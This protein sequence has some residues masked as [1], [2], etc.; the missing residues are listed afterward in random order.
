[1][2]GDGRLD[3]Q[4]SIPAVKGDEAASRYQFLPTGWEGGEFELPRDGSMAMLL[5]TFAESGSRGLNLRAYVVVDYRDP[6][7]EDLASQQRLAEEDRIC[8]YEIVTCG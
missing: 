2:S 4:R 1:M 7:L 3:G 6:S 8:N 5:A